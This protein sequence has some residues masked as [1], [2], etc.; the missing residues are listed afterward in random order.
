MND[1]QARAVAAAEAILG[2]ALSEV[3]ALSDGE[4][5]NLILRASTPARSIIIKATRTKD[6]D[7]SSAEAFELGLVKE[8]VATAFLSRHAPGNAPAFLGGNAE[9]GL[10]VFEDLGAGIGSLVS[11]LLDGPSDVAE[12]ALVGYAAAIGRLHAETLPCIDKHADQLRRD[13]PGATIKPPVGGRSWRAAVAD[14]VTGLLGGSLPE[15]EI[16]TV[17]NRLAEPGPWLGLAHRDNCPDNVLLSDGRARLIDFE[18]AG[19]GHVLLDTTYWRMGFP[20]C[21][22]AG[23]VPETVID[24]MDRAY[25]AELVRALPLAADDERFR[26][27]M[28]ILLFVRLFASLSWLL[29]S[30]LR[31]DSKWGVSTNRPRLLWHL[32]ATISGA[33]GV[34]MLAGL[35]TTAMRWRQ[36][37]A[38]RW[39]DAGPLA[40]F[41]A[42]RA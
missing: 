26:Q 14:K 42:F 36:E 37:L 33:A 38:Q 6:Y 23:R 8:W 24:L 16:A 30:A 27:E 18:W 34:S 2:T 19:P 1:E 39:P 5:R 9:T 35:R 41:P 40:L 7:A 4:R 29:E 31:E 11:P 20:T 25:R 13:F 22:C 17:A 21:W 3:T 12:R 15:A 28:A 10:I 32:D